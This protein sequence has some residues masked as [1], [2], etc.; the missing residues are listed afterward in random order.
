MAQ[1][2]LIQAER[3]Y[4]KPVETWMIEIDNET[5]NE[6]LEQLKTIF[7]TEVAKIR[8]SAPAGSIAEMPTIGFGL[9]LKMKNPKGIWVDI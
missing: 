3:S 9:L 6:T 7:N 2:I 8:D 5:G 4:Y 1:P